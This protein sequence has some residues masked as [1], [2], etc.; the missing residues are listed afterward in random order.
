[1]KQLLQDQ[2]KKHNICIIKLE[3]TE[4]MTEKGK[5]KMFNMIIKQNFP[6]KKVMAF[7]I[8]RNPDHSRGE[9]IHFKKSYEEY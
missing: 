8:D 3:F 4:R 2:F 1:M 5:I 9:K 7:Q 6:K